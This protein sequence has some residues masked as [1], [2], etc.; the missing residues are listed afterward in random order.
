MISIVDEKIAIKQS[1]RWR[2]EFS[3][4]P[5][6]EG[7]VMT[8]NVSDFPAFPSVLSYVNV[9][10]LNLKISSNHVFRILMDESC[11][12]MLFILGSS[13]ASGSAHF[14]FAKFS[15]SYIS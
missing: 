2:Q 7:D 13:D 14:V 5:P 15:N 12:E 10:F 4:R 6:Y 3:K 8:I 9:C 11:A 1:V